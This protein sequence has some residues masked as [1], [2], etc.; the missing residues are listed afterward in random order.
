MRGATE[1]PTKSDYTFFFFFCIK[2]LK[3]FVTCW[4]DMQIITLKHFLYKA[5]QFY[6]LVGHKIIDF[7]EEKHCAYK[8]H[9]NI[10]KRYD[11]GLT[12]EMGSTGEFGRE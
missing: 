5:I 12:G 7:V 6:L 1:K 10:G 3:R 8:N 4:G 11:V 9:V 2:K